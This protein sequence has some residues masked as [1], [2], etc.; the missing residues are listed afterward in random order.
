MRDFVADS[1]K[2]ASLMHVHRNLRTSQQM[3]GFDT[4]DPFMF[5]VSSPKLVLGLTGGLSV[6]LSSLPVPCSF[7]EQRSNTRDSTYIQPR[8]HQVI[9]IDVE[10]CA[11]SAFLKTL[12]EIIS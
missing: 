5:S 11:K 12:A 3:V 8:L 9:T 4:T 2:L 7:V 10:F 6:S 1:V